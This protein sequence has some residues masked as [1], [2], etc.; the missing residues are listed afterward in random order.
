VRTSIVVVTG[1]AVLLFAV[2]LAVAIRNM[3]EGEA[4]T[5][6]QRDAIRVA[7]VVPDTVAADQTTVRLPKDLDTNLTVG[8]YNVFGR[9][10]R[11]HGP[12]TS[13]IA[14]AAGDGRVHSAVQGT[15][16]VVSAP[17]PGDQA[18]AATVRVST[19]NGQ[20]IERTLRAWA[21]MALLG[22]CVVGVAALLAW[23]QGRRIVSPLERLTRSAR[24]LGDGD[25]TI[26]PERSRIAETDTLADALEATAG[27]LGELL[28]RERAFSTQVSHQLRTPLT[29]L[30][31]GLESALSR[32]GADLRQAAAVALR[33]GEQLHATIEDLLRLARDT[34]LRGRTPLAVDELLAT[35]R[36]QWRGAFT[37]RDRTLLVTAN[38]GLPEVHA[39]A[40]GVRHVVDVLVDNALVHGAGTTVV[41]A[42]TVAD[43]LLIEVSDEGPG[44]TDPD[45]AFAPR[46]HHVDPGANGRGDT[47]G[48]GL[49]LARS[50]AEAEGGRLLLRHPAPRPVFGLLLPEAHQ[51][52]D[53]PAADPAG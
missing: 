26:N 13:A 4:V 23:Y 50:L 40:T 30:L 7:A 48:I 41:S 32:P 11:E 17:V 42:H 21:I 25:F 46:S 51:N 10:I 29:A 9:L 33:R 27:R 24:A 18:V 8:I 49:A 53:R 39:S 6:L 52:G 15:D 38:P 37:E 47:H 5:S 12:G 28:E 36:D 34:H 14:A 45:A 43:G 19:P 1:L 44:L 16:L 3:Y 2:P 31:L 20:V 35:V 22:A